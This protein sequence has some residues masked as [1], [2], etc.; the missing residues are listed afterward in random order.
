MAALIKLSS[1]G[2]VEKIRLAWGSVAPTIA[3]SPEIEAALIG[4]PLSRAVLG[5]AKT[6]LDGAIS[7]I[8]DIRATA[9]YRR[10]VAANLLVRLSRYNGHGTV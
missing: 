6:L 5:E 4:K 8:D 3:L 1:E 9:Q 2:V 7:P 10:T